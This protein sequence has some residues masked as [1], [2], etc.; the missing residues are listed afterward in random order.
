MNIT[1][2]IF[3]GLS[4]LRSWA[5]K[6]CMASGVLD[7]VLNL[8]QVAGTVM[9]PI[10]KLV[11]LQ[12]DEIKVAEKYEYDQANDAI[13]GHYRYLQVVNARSIC[14]KWKQPIFADFDQNIT[15]EILYNLC[16]KL[17]NIGFR[18]VA[19]VSDCGS[20]NTGL[21]T[22]LEISWKKPWIKHPCMDFFFDGPPHMLKLALR[23]G[24]RPKTRSTDN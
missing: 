4:T 2:S 3:V 16:T 19:C 6:V 13:L 20:T 8:L 24:F 21:W 14:G 17:S 18:V 12:Y 7:G 23:Y 10:K 15:Q 22:K 5:S 1:V 9:S 11:V